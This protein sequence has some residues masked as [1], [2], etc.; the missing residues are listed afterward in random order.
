MDD[1]I[2]ALGGMRKKNVSARTGA[3]TFASCN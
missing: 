2:G 3:E 1:I